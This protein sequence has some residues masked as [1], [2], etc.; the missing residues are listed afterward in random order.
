MGFRDLKLFNQDMLRKQGWRLVSNPEPLC[1]RVIKGKYYPHGDFLSAT[2]KKKSSHTWRALLHG[3]ESLKKGLIKR[4]RPGDSVNIWE[5]NWPPGSVTL[6]PLYKRLEI[7]LTHVSE[8]M[9]NNQRAWNKELVDNS[10]TRL[11]AEAILQ[12]PLGNNL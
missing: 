1:S 4:I 12:V 2:K 6:K 3:R 7:H 5:D 10:F 11:D 9:L 8:L